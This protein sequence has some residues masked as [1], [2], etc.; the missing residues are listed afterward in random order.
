M[1][2]H[3]VAAEGSVPALLEADAAQELVVRDRVRQAVL[4][5]SVP[6]DVER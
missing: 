5:A 3:F 1:N 4:D 2:Q 6:A